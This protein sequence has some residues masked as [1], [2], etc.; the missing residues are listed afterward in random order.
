[1]KLIELKKRVDEVP[2]LATLPGVTAELLSILQSKNV[3]FEYTAAIIETDPALTTKIF[4]AV[5]SSNEKSTEKIDSI[6]QAI[7][8]LGLNETRT[9]LFYFTVYSKLFRFKPEQ[10]EWMH[11]F[12]VHS[13]ACAHVSRMLAIR[14]GIHNENRE[15]TAGLLHDLGK[16]FLIQFLPDQCTHILQSI[17]QTFM[18]DID[19]ENKFLGAT[20]ATIGG[21]LAERWGL[22]PSYIETM[23]YHH[24]PRMATIDQPLVALINF[25]ETCCIKIGYGFMEGSS[26]LPIDHSRGWAVL[27]PFYPS[28]RTLDEI[29]LLTDI[30]S[31]LKNQPGFTTLAQG[32][33]L[34]PTIGTDHTMNVDVLR[35]R[36]DAIQELDSLPAITTELLAFLDDPNV[37]LGKLSVIVK[38]NQALGERVLRIVNSPFYDFRDRIRTTQQAAAFLGLSEFT[39]LLLT[40]SFISKLFS[41]KSGALPHIEAYW[42]HAIG[43]GMISHSLASRLL[44]PTGGLEFTAGVLHNLGKLVLLEHFSGTAES[45]ITRIQSEKCSDIQAEMAMVGVPHTEIGGWVAEKWNLPASYIEV[46][47]CHHVPSQANVNALLVST[48]H[49]ADVLLQIRNVGLPEGPMHIDMTTDEGWQTLVKVHPSARNVDPVQLMTDIQF[50]VKDARNFLAL[51]SGRNIQTHSL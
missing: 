28:L 36:V 4:R 31:E 25:A 1:M 45:I 39:N 12:W 24:D 14:F 10:Q 11:Q 16:L 38:S 26:S 8:H 15:F 3:P 35:A 48:I 34:F 51:I 49:I 27:E 6:H 30:K 5:Y 40:I 7:S 17:T 47:R 46:I 21:W 37:S 9:I 22:P 18:S 32:D 20:H 2:E 42:D 19:A 43:C 44:L 41:E 13:V 29:D 23:K 50:S 33:N